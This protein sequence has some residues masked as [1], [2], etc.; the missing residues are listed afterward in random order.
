MLKTSRLAADE[1]LTFAVFF[2]CE[3][4]GLKERTSFWVE[5]KVNVKKTGAAICSGFCAE[6]KDGA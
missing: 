1:N 4:A 3:S 5:L 2:T 6:W